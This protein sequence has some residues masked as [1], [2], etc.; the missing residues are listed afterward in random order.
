MDSPTKKDLRPNAIV[1][2]TLSFR[3]LC[4]FTVSLPLVA[5]F[6]CFVT[7]YIFQQDDIHET[8]CRV[9]IPERSHWLIVTVCFCQ[10]YNIIP[11][12]SAVTGI[13][14]QRYLWRICIA[15]HIGPRFL[16]ASVYRTYHRSLLQSETDPIVRL[17]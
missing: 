16:I 8:H 9:S 10:V 11:S 2:F 1:Y 12:I 17:S 5:L 15:L 7:A 14:P 13:S 4:L 6:T 3:Q